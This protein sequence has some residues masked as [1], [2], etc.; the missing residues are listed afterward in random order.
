MRNPEIR[1][2]VRESDIL[3]RLRSASLNPDELRRGWLAEAIDEIT[4][5]RKEAARYRFL[6]D[7]APF[8]L[9]SLACKNSGHVSKGYACPSDVLMAKTPSAAIDAAIAYKLNTPK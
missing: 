7:C 9:M 3:D 1:N 5:L 2:P 8:V 6:E 4:E